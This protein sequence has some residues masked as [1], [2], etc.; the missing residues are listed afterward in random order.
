MMRRYGAGPLHLVGHVAL[1]AVAGY[2]LSRALQPRFAPEPLN[3]AAWLF[4]GALIHDLLLLPAYGL[5]DA[6]ARRALPPTL[7]NHVRIPVALS[8]IV[9]LVYAPR[10][11]DRQ[12]QNVINALGEPPPDYLT[13]W[14]LLTAGLFIASAL[15][16]AFRAARAARGRRPAA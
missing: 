4:A 9:F 5:A 12:P 15:V 3:L 16:Y 11:L 6:A 7:L 1:I 2:A 14:A 13:R 10:I 8:G